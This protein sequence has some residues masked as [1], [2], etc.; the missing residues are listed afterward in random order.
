MPLTLDAINERIMQ[1]KI[2][3]VYTD[4]VPPPSE[5]YDYILQI[6]WDKRPILNDN[7]EVIGL[8]GI[9]WISPKK[10]NEKQV[11]NFGWLICY[12]IIGYKY[13]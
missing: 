6:G 5:E 2:R 12:L 13:I 3:E 9:D 11:C 4:G 10:R 7:G 1:T 8:L